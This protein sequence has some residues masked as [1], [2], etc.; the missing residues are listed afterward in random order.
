M[1]VNLRQNFYKSRITNINHFLN[2]KPKENYYECSI[3]YVLFAYICSEQGHCQW[4]N[5]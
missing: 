4:Y 1:I 3:A 2:G 5:C